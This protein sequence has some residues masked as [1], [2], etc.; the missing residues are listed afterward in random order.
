M[1]SYKENTILAKDITLT[2]AKRQYDTEAKNLL[3]YR[4]IV[5]KETP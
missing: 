4:C 1:S 3:S 5:T 2:D